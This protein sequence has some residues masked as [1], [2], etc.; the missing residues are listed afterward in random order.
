MT[1][2]MKRLADLEDL[3]RNPSCDNFSRS[4]YKKLKKLGLGFLDDDMVDETTIFWTISTTE[5][6]NL[7]KRLADLE[8]KVIALNGKLTELPSEKE[9]MFNSALL[10]LA[11]LEYGTK[12]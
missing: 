5:Y 2:L 11:A 1:W 3:D 9:E 7:M 6:L 12:P 8:E 10:R 4:G